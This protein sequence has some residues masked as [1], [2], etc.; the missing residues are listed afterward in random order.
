MA[1]AGKN[2]LETFRTKRRTTGRDDP[3]GSENQGDLTDRRD[4]PKNAMKL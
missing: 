2:G 1:K 3:A 4:L